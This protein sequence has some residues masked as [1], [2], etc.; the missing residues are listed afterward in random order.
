MADNA[1]SVRPIE[2]TIGIGINTG[3]RDRWDLLP[4]KQLRKVVD[5]L[6]FGLTKHGSAFGW[7]ERSR[8]EH[9]ESFERHVKE[10]L[11]GRRVDH[12]TKL[13]TLAHVMARA[14]FL[15]WHDDNPKQER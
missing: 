9:E 5:V 10:Y 3:K 6:T 11:S 13:P 14:L 2:N 8:A 12:E 1:N 4:W 7:Q 15:M